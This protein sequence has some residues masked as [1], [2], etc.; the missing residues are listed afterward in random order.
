V[1]VVQNPKSRP[2]S[3]AHNPLSCLS[4]CTQ[5]GFANI[6]IHL[7]LET[8]AHTT[9]SIQNS[10]STQP[11]Q[12]A[13]PKNTKSPRLSIRQYFQP[14]PRTAPSVITKTTI[15]SSISDENT[16][17]PFSANN[18]ASI[19]S[20]SSSPPS[21]PWSPTLLR[22][23]ISTKPKR[24]LNIKS[25]LHSGTMSSLGDHTLPFPIDWDDVAF[26][27]NSAKEDN[28]A[29]PTRQDVSAFLKHMA[30]MNTAPSKTKPSAA[31][32][33]I[34]TTLAT[35]KSVLDFCNI[36][37]FLYNTTLK[38]DVKCHDKV[39]RACIQGQQPLKLEPGILLD[40]WKDDKGSHH[41]IFCVSVASSRM[42]QKYGLQALEDSYNVLDG[43]AIDED[44]LFSYTDEHHGKVPVPRYKIYFQTIDNEFAALVLAESISSAGEWYHGPIC[45]YFHG[46]VDP[47]HPPRGTQEW[48]SLDNIFSVAVSVD[49][50]CVKPRFQRQGLATSLVDV[51]RKSFGNGPIGKRYVAFSRPTSSGARFATKYCK[52]VNWQAVDKE[53]RT[54]K[55]PFVVN[56]ADATY[57][58]DQGRLVE[59]RRILKQR[60]I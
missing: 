9:A 2:T 24:R 15:L 18:Q 49:R 50:V 4:S 16:I 32:S 48:V 21:E 29:Q 26:E 20:P 1:S 31:K 33:Y 35:D 41:Q 13:V 53:G 60:T 22:K 11:V 45:Y 44:D 59:N 46:P 37:K 39:H 28:N 58:I 56:P 19:S 12:Q 25:A 52:G 57:H 17:P 55:L 36:C 3:L 5:V 40:D 7:D 51:V 34:Q 30:K 10:L 8:Q 14:L 6:Y 42:W 38:E 54:Y 47:R 23:S 43:P 27:Q